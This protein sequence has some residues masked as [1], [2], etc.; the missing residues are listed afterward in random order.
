MSVDAYGIHIG[1]LYFRFYGLLIMAGLVLG[2]AV[3]RRLLQQM[4][5][6]VDPDVA[7][8]AILWGT[9]FGVIGARLYHILTP[10]KAL[11]AQGI[12]TMYY[13]THP[14]DAIAIWRGGLGLPGAIAGG[15]LGVYLFCRRRGISFPLALDAAAVGI[16]VGHALGR[17]GNYVNQELYGPPTDLP[18]GIYIRPENRIP[19]YEAFERFHPL[20]LYEG[21]WNLA[22]AGVIYWVWRRYGKRLKRGDLFLLYLIGYPLGRFL[23]EFLRIDFVP[24]FGINFNQTLMLVIAVASAV[25]FYR[26][27]RRRGGTK[28]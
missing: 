13:L 12:D 16:P 11:L 20:F 6:K 9:V 7:W 1:P 3:A 22:L 23:L 18:W 19:G 14:L 28:G 24:L 5:R 15:V 2:T 27:H 8:D 17:W 21:L 10:S 4:D 26:R 25:V